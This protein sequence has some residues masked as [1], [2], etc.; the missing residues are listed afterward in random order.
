MRS[1]FYFLVLLSV[2]Q[3]GAC[4][5]DEE[6]LPDV[7]CDGTVPAYADV[8]AFK[9][10]TTCHSSKLSGAARNDAPKDV[11]FDTESAAKAHAEEAAHEV[12]EGE[13]PPEDS[14]LTLTESEKTDLYKWALCP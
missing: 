9:K 12:Y 8:D 2:S 13:M 14:G 5:D 7:D 10:C 3:L 11:N 4:G 6:E 1:W